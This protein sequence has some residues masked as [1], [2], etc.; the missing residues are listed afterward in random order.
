M[1]R[2][3]IFV[4]LPLYVLLTAIVFPFVIGVPW[5]FFFASDAIG[6]ST[7]AK[8]LLSYG[9]YTFDGIHPYIDREPVMS[10][11]LVPLYALTGIENG[12][13][14]AIVQAAL[15][16]FTSW[17]FCE[18]FSYIT[19]SRAAGITFLLILTSGSV[20]HTVF[21]AYRECLVMSL[22][23]LFAGLW[24]QDMRTFR[25]SVLMGLLLGLVI[26]AYFSFVLLPIFLLV[27]WLLQ[28]RPMKHFSAVLLVCIFTVSLWGLRNA[29]YDGRFRIIENHRTAVMWHVRGEQAE[30][31]RGLEPF[32][33]LWSEY[34][35]RDWNGRS[36]ACSY[37]GL[38]HT[39]WPA[40]NV[41]TAE[42][43]A[44]TA[45]EGKA[46]IVQFFPSYLWF[47]VFEI[48]ELHFPFVGGGWSHAFNVYASL[49]QLMLAIG[50][51]LGLIRIVDRKILILVVLIAYNTGVFIFTDATPRYMLPVFFCYAAIAGI[52]YD[53]MLKRFFRSS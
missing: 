30:R 15:I 19:S 52:G 42:S 25:V 35:S 12:I 48:L 11:F 17:F 36:S 51:L 32:R 24:I 33:C 47:S 1:K 43:N 53:L 9:F 34:I 14:V 23:L 41:S 49:T 6:Y 29:S 2:S 40:G 44:I 38:M 16:Y 8:N 28:K 31:V 26:L 18:R 39:K 4:G 3:W 45:K 27:A 7:G 46:K 22:L 13:A 21:S 10:F 50:F 37:N 5:E 20:L